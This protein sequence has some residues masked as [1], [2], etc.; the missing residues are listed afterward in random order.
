MV[1]VQVPISAITDG[2]SVQW[3]HIDGPLLSW[4]GLM[5]WLTWRERFAVWIGR[6]TIDDIA[7]A[8]WPH[9][10]RARASFC[11]EQSCHRNGCHGL[12]G[13]VV[14]R[15]RQGTAHE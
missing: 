12:L 15:A 11:N 3:N 4:A 14:A 6:K 10:Q 2:P 8:R 13:C 7:Y 5:H 9:L 1:D